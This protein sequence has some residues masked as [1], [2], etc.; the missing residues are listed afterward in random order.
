MNVLITGGAGYIGS[1]LAVRHAPSANVTVLDNL[2]RGTVKP[3]GARFCE[4]DIRDPQ[5]LDELTRNVDVIYHL[6]AESA[7]MAA[8]ADPEYC[9]STNVT[10]TFRVLQAARDNGVRRIVFS[11]SREVYGESAQLPV[12]ESAHLQARNIYGASKAAGEMCCGVFPREM[13]IV[14]LSNVY[15]PADKGRVIPLFVNSAL[16]GLPLTLFGG[17]QLMDFVWIDTVV[18]ALVRLGSGPHVAG[19]LNIASGTGVTIVDLAKRIV[20][21]ANSTSTVEV[22]PRRDM[23]VMR[24]TANVSA[25]RAALD[26]PVPDDPLF[27]LPAVIQHA[28]EHAPQFTR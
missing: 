16:Q 9:F 6:A 8:D 20:S 4:G 7:V 1:R 3:E 23:E 11:S 10:G 21:L 15:G 14:R 24:Y 12:H 26:L 25:A 22:V 18:D 19:P 17:Q 13:S 2:H 5:I 28:L 27:G